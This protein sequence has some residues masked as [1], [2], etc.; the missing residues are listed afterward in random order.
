[1]AL[2]ATVRN[3]ISGL[4]SGTVNTM[5][6]VTSA[7]TTT[8]STPLVG[9]G[10]VIY[11]T[12]PVALKSVLLIDEAEDARQRAILEARKYHEGLHD[13]KLTARLKQFLGDNA[14]IAEIRLNFVQKVNKPV[15]SRLI[16]ESF[17]ASSQN[18]TDK[19]NQVLF[20]DD[21]WR[22]SRM[23]G[24]RARMLLETVRDGEYFLFVDFDRDNNR[25]RLTPHQRYTDPTVGGDGE[26][27]YLK[28]PN[29]DIDQKPLYGVKRWSEQV[30]NSNGSTTPEPRITIYYDDRIERYAQR[31][32]GWQLAP[33][34]LPDG[35]ELPAEE[36][37]TDTGEEGGAPLG[38]PLVH[39]KTPGLEPAAKEAIPIQKG[40][41]KTYVDMLASSD[42]QAFPIP[43]SLGFEPPDGPVEP[44]WWIWAKAENGQTVAIDQ[45]EA[46]DPNGFITLI[47]KQIALMAD[48]TE[49]PL[50]LL[51]RSAQRAAEGTLQ[52]E[53]ESFAVKVRDY[54]E[55][56]EMALEDA[57]KIARRLHNVYLGSIEGKPHVALDEGASFSVAWAPISTRSTQDK[58]DEAEAWLAAGVPVEEIWSAILGF[59]AKKIKA[60]KKAQQVA[61]FGDGFDA[62][63]TEGGN[64]EETDEAAA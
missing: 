52:E 34:P 53:K 13:V 21:V 62:E 51:Q 31:S 64:D 60:L 19:A 27:C 36:W 30:L 12:T 49:T 46:A 37:N 61:A 35:A 26:G 20:A 2:L 17:Q 22:G 24:K 54:A 14:P 4:W 10:G 57:F 44:G 42:L 23:K 38:I 1:M 6:T 58:A 43:V 28:Y 29:N 47:D 45:I 41:N 11:D 59:D 39:I 15:A 9:N 18:E 48:V 25:P 56:I 16:I 32:N 63:E 33:L 40:L 5:N 50:T 7:V 3:Y 8:L 55:T